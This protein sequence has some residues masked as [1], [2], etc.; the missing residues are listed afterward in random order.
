MSLLL[1][2]KARG[3]RKVGIKPEESCYL[4]G[5]TEVHERYSRASSTVEETSAYCCTSMHHGSKPRVVACR[6][7]GLAFVPEDEISERLVEMYSDVVDEA[8]L[9]HQEGRRKTFR[10]AYRKIAPHLPRQKGRLIEIGSYCGFFLE[11]CR[12][13]G[14]EVKGIE[15]SRWAARYSREE[16]G[17]DVHEGTLDDFLAREVDQFDVAVLWDVLEHMKDPRGALRQVNRL[18]PRGGLLC[19]ST[20]DIDNWFPRLL[21]RHWPWLMDMHLFYFR[22]KLMGRLFA[23]AGFEL[24]STGSYCHQIPARYLVEKLKY[25]TPPL[26]SWIPGIIRALMPG[27]LIIP[28]RFGDI[29]L[30]VARKTSSSFI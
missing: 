24:V 29:K 13:E 2:R 3:P 30:Y 28:F 27:S 26:L 15:P 14:W 4:C 20:L 6:S 12:D 7:C 25:L 8:Y 16:K 1:K 22:R 18:L 19:L 23:Q 11:I 9:R 17:L 21:G 10:W 5:S